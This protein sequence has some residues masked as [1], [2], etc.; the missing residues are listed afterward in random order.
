LEVRA[1]QFLLGSKCPVSQGI[2]VKEQDPLGELPA[3][4]FLQIS[5]NREVGRA[6]ELPT[7]LNEIKNKT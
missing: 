1:D 6:K 3:A 5:F 4:F 7:E 2:V